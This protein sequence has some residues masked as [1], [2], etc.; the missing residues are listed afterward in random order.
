MTNAAG[1]LIP[2]FG[3]RFDKIGSLYLEDSQSAFPSGAPSPMN[4]STPRVAS[5]SVA[6]P[7]PGDS[8]TPKMSYLGSATARPLSAALSLL[9]AGKPPIPRELGT[10]VGPIVSWP[11]F[12]SHRGELTKTEDIDRGPFASTFDYLIGCAFREIRGVIRENEGK[13]APHRISLDPDEVR[14]YTTVEIRP[15]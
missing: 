15:D 1:L 4:L 7:R 11:F 6:T 12:G 3:H 2:L 13:A 10:V 9:A 5:S 14:P 8:A